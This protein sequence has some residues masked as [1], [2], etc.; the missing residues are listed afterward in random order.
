MTILNTF[1]T[2]FRSLVHPNTTALVKLI[3]NH[4]F[5]LSFTAHPVQWFSGS[6]NFVWSTKPNV[7]LCFNLNPQVALEM[8][9]LIQPTIKPIQA[10]FGL[11]IV[12]IPYEPYKVELMPSQRCSPNCASKF[13]FAYHG[14]MSNQSYLEGYMHNGSSINHVT[15]FGAFLT[16]LPSSPFYGTIGIL[17]LEF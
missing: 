5:S 9:P 8:H 2:T 16:P 1:R 10:I 6:E 4:P 11:V 12:K 17:G 15:S 3:F 7:Q 13:G 14:F